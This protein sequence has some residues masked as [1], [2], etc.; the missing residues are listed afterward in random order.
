M[1]RDRA[2]N[3]IKRPDSFDFANL[4]SRSAKLDLPKRAVV[5]TYV[6]FPYDIWYSRYFELV[7]N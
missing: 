2:P 7:I 6:S 1:I 4:E 3:D 5:W